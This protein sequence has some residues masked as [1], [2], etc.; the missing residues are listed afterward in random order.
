M[1][2]LN[3]VM[4]IRKDLEDLHDLVSKI[5]EALDLAYN[6]DTDEYLCGNVRKLIATEIY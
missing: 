6:I 2:M 3:N 5:K 1:S 4:D